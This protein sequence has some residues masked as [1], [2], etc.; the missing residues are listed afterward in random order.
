MSQHTQVKMS[1]KKRIPTAQVITS[2]DKLPQSLRWLTIN[3]R[4]ISQLLDAP[5]AD[6]ALRARKW[7]AIYLVDD[8]PI[9]AT[10]IQERGQPLQ[11]QVMQG[12]ARGQEVRMAVQAVLLKECVSEEIACF[13]RLDRVDPSGMKWIEKRLTA[14]EILVVRQG[15][16][17]D[18]PILQ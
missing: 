17:G 4:K 8:S 9:V 10:I 16:V 5:M 7:H 11:V 13:L 14:G 2:D 3:A 1:L 18:K 12:Y 15:M 6:E